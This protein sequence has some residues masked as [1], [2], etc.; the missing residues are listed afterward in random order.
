[1]AG[2]LLPLELSSFVGRAT[3]LERIPAVLQ[4]RRLVTVTE[5]GGI[6]VEVGSIVNE[7]GCAWLGEAIEVQ[8]RFKRHAQATV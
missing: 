3:E 8:C 6:G 2:S 7:D 4:S 5:P 1:M